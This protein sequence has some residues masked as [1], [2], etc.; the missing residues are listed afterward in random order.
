MDCHILNAAPIWGLKISL[1]LRWRGW[2]V[3]EMGC[4]GL[5]LRVCVTSSEGR[6]CL[7]FRSRD[8][9]QP[10]LGKLGWA[11]GLLL[12]CQWG[13][14]MTSVSGALDLGAHSPGR[15]FAPAA[16]SN[17]QPRGAGV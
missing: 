6:A 3:S 9:P 14:R 17:Q 1:R 12:H 7:K 4:P 16:L 11:L 13:T 5:L 8:G 15:P 10:S 2:A